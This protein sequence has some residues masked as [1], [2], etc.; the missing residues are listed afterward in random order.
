MSHSPFPD[1]SETIKQEWGQG[2]SSKYFASSPD[3]SLFLDLIKTL[4]RRET[5]GVIFSWWR[6]AV[7][8]LCWTPWGWEHNITRLI[9]CDASWKQPRDGVNIR[10]RRPL[11]PSHDPRDRNELNKAIL[12]A[13]VTPQWILMNF[14]TILHLF[15]CALFEK[16]KTL[17]IARVGL[18][19]FCEVSLF[20]LMTAAEFWVSALRLTLGFTQCR[21][22]E[23]SCSIS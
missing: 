15:Y 1:L 4:L 23:G 14:F 11:L 21:E 22:K 10:V 12:S 6:W 16:N 9:S 7:F 18:E 5:R 20:H 8:A 19:Y 17:N 2:N 13:R 3:Y